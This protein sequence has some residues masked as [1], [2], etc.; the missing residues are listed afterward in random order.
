LDLTSVTCS[1]PRKTVA[2]DVTVAGFSASLA[3]IQIMRDEI[4]D[5]R[6]LAGLLE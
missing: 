3:S 1:V 6:G 5:V 4:E 2:P